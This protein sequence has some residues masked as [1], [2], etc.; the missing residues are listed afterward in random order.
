MLV[1][2]MEYRFMVEL[3]GRAEEREL[4]EL[5]EKLSCSMT[6]GIRSSAITT[7]S[8]HFSNPLRRWIGPFRAG[9]LPNAF[10]P[11]GKE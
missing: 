6:C 10:H 1:G 2:L 9:R 11:G 8:Y 4:A 5:L 3:T 7:P